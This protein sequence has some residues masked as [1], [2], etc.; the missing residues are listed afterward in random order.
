MAAAVVFRVAISGLSRFWI[1]LLSIGVLLL[2]VVSVEA[3]TTA[4]LT[5]SVL[6]LTN[7]VLQGAEVVVV[8]VDTLAERR[9]TSGN[10]GNFVIASLPPGRYNL[11]S[12]IAGFRPAELRNIL[13][14]VNDRVAVRVEMSV[15]SRD[16]GVT[17]VAEVGRV[18]TSPAVSTVIDRQ[19][20]ENLPLSGRSLQ[21]LLELTPGVVLVPADTRGAGGQFSV[22]GQRANANYFTVDGVSA[23]AAVGSSVYTFPGQA[24]SGQLP[25]MNA[26]G[27]T[28]GL[29]SV[30]ALQEFRIQTSTYA[31]EFGRTPGGQV[32]MVTRSGTNLFHGSVFEYFRDDAMDA[33]DWFTNNRAQPEPELRQHN[34]GGVVGGP[35]LRNRLFFFGSYERLQLRQPRAL[36]LSVLS[37]AAR[38]S[39]N[40][41]IQ[42]LLNVFP[43]PNGRD[44]G[45]G[46]AEFSAS[47]SDPSRSDSTSVRVDHNANEALR[48]FARVSRAPSYSKQRTGTLSY[49]NATNVNSDSAT[50]GATW[51][52]SK[53]MVH[54]LRVSY[55]QSEGPY[56]SEP[57]DFGG[58]APPPLSVFNFG[59]Q[60]GNALVSVFLVEGGTWSWGTGSDFR[61]RQLNMVHSTTVTTASHE[62]KFGVDYRRTHPLLSGAVIGSESYI[63]SVPLLTQGRAFSYSVN[64]RDPVR[65]AVAFDNL[66][67]FAQ[68][69]WKPHGRLTLTYGVRWEFVPP[70]HATE[71]P[72]AV[73]LENA[74]DAYGG[75]VHLA[76]RDTPLWDTRYIDFAPRIGASYKLIDR[77]NAPLII[78]GGFGVFYDVGFGHVAN[79]Y[80]PTYPLTATRRTS[81]PTV[82]LSQDVLGLPRLV[83]DPPQQL[84]VMDRHM[85]QPFTHQWN[86][87]TEQSLGANQTITIGYVGASGH[88]LLKFERYNIPLLEW[89]GVS[90]PVMLNRN[91]GYSDYHG[92]QLQVQRRLAKGMQSMVSYTLGRSRDTASDDTQASVPAER[93]LPSID[94][95]YSDFD[96][97]HVLTAAMTWQIP[98]LS[99]ASWWKRVIHDW[100]VDT[101]VRARSAFPLRITAIVPFPPDNQ[102]VR[103]NV[104]SG[105]PVWL[106][107]PAVPEGRRLNRQAFAIPAS[108]TQGSLRRGSIRGFNARQVDMAVRRDFRLSN[109]LRLQLRF[110]MFNVF[111][112]PNFYD[113]IGTLQNGNFGVSTLT[114]GRGLGGLTP[115]YQMGGPRSSQVA[116]K[117][118]F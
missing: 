41:E 27:G 18:S 115:L 111:N 25:T 38:Q 6:D 33:I 81:S 61:Q 88:R 55:S 99:G 48:F 100:G 29:V 56:M 16:E 91:L 24:A 80:G 31:P 32:S 110:E 43:V 90:I 79:G 104:V 40:P 102:T 106:E 39:A 112:T 22:N 62:W 3:Q 70:P 11:R 20:V 50:L 54:D 49:S 14:N 15:A 30:D 60:P 117:V 118:L 51:I 9:A 89:P 113:P 2:T 105:Q 28:N 23:N 21:S 13:L 82:P 114:L 65:Q 42:E 58:A 59:R 74:E 94:Y 84:F 26:L 7:S 98:E 4:T 57:D 76:P 1:G 8:N 34:F 73:T 116:A 85:R 12:A 45:G 86:V 75:N 109:R 17:V 96:L 35:V 69:S 107:D 44:L 10:D 46:L 97:R 95:G 87:S 37:L 19:F 66:S 77:A 36:T 64:V 103:P 108:N 52:A 101:I 47:F 72:N 53:R 71:G 67:I 5:G 63:F 93:M 78:R 68:D 92:L 83:V